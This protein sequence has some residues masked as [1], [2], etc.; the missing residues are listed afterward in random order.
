VLLA[1]RIWIGESLRWYLQRARHPFKDYIVGH[2]WHWFSKRRVW[3]KYDQGLAMRVRLDD[4]VQQRIFFDRYYEKP[5]IEWLGRTLTDADVFW[6]VG[7]NVG[8]VTLVASRR[9]RQVVSF[10]PDPRSLTTLRGHIAANHLSNV[11]VVPSALGERTETMV[12]HQA[13]PRN[14]GRT[15]LL[16]DRGPLAS[17][18]EVA[19]TSADEFLAAH[20]NLAPTVMKIDVEGAEHLVLRGAESLLRAGGLRAIVFEDQGDADRRPTSREVVERLTAAGYRIEPLGESDQSAKDG[21]L[22]FVATRARR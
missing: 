5:L 17:T 4:Y 10:E 13:D 3:V 11:E 18:V 12:L 6:D 20:A 2:Y 22:N 8:A 9:C 16:R 19:V 1:P 7:T 14:T 15:S 21:M